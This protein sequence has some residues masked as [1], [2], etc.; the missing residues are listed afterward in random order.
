MLGRQGI[1]GDLATPIS[2]MV[3]VGRGARGGVLIK[4]AEGLELM[5]KVE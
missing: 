4:D 1:S 3:G 5:Q 2:I